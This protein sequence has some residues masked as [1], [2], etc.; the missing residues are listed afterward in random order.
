MKGNEKMDFSKI[1]VLLTDGGARQTLTILHG[2]KEI[3]CHVTVLCSSRL[4]VC[5]ASRLPDEKILHE[6]AAGSFP[7]FEDFL[8]GVVASGK[9]DVLLPVAEITTNKVT[10][11]EDEYKKYLRIACAPRASYIQAFNKQRTFEVALDNGIPCP[12][13]RRENQDIE[14]FLAN[15]KFP[16]IIKPRQGLGSIGFHK[17]VTEAEFRADLESGKLNVDEYVVQEF[18]KFEKRV[19][20]YIFVD[21]NNNVTTAM[22]QDVLRWF[23]IDAG[24]AVLTQ[25]VDAPDAVRYSGELLQAMNWRGF[26]NVGFM[27]DQD[28][29][30]PMLLE[31]NG[32]ISAGVKLSLM[33]GFNVARQLIELAYDE[34]V[35]AYPPNDK[36]GLMARH[37]QADVTWFIK[38]P[39]RFRSK[40]SWFSWKNT[41]DLV[42]WANDPLPWFAYSL[43]KVFG[44]K[45]SMNKR[46]H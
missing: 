21:Q 41:K 8:G 27:I 26:A 31:I 18:V 16:I 1:K 10:S 17:Y 43:K 14:D 13:T 45:E 30:K 38:S 7:E 40:P 32:R 44:Y 9:Y 2:L 39:N 3:G 25:S 24:T 42:F 19:G 46:K 28:T 33:C 23:P 37:T 11:H 36:F 12:Y 35:T 22:A 20:T 34:P 4:D 5:Y 15:A 6:D 29:G